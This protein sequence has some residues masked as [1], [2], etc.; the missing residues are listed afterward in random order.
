MSNN[1]FGT[2]NGT[3]GPCPVELSEWKEQPRLATALS[4]V[5]WDRLRMRLFLTSVSAVKRIVSRV[6]VLRGPITDTPRHHIVLYI[7]TCSEVYYHSIYN[8]YGYLCSDPLDGVTGQCT[9]YVPATI[10]LP[11][12]LVGC[13]TIIIWAV[14]RHFE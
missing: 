7:F 2:S 14:H 11:I 4:N 6:I 1:I 3:V 5:L 9:W 13:I 8:R 12:F 10:F